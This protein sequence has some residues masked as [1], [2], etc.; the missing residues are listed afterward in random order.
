MILKGSQRGGARQLSGHLMNRRDNEHVSLIEVRGFVGQSLDEALAEAHAI[1]KGTKCSQ[2]LFSLSMN[3]PADQPVGEE[4]LLRAADAAEERLGLEGQPRAV[5]VHE[6]EGRRHAHVVWSRIDPETMHAINLPFFKQRL[7]ELSRELYL[8]QDWPLP[9]GM[10]QNGGK[11]PL[12]FTLAEWQQAKRLGLDPRE[13]KQVFRDAWSRSDSRPAFERA[14][15]E[16]GYFLAKGDRR[17]FVAVDVHGD[18]FAISK[19]AGVRAREVEQR[20]GNPEALRDVDAVRQDI[21][22]R[23]NDRLKGFIGEVKA[24]HGEA[25]A[26][27]DAERQTMTRAHAADRTRLEQ[28]QQ[29]RQREEQQARQA[30]FNRGLRGLWDKLTGREKSI[31]Q[32]NETEALLAM[33]RDR[34]QRDQLAAAQI[35]QR[36]RL[37]EQIEA[38]RRQQAEERKLLAREVARRMRQQTRTPNTEPARNRTRTRT[39]ASDPDLKP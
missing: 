14:L 25:R 10:R 36:R 20:F 11:S 8:E 15:E 29:E 35:E 1:A 39:R 32:H 27:L 21:R 18:V 38:L 12:N 2:F 4:A 31:R 22:Q 19:W 16:R 13:L 24:R 28:L 3:P 7:T 26:P 30:K 33:R 5:V 17:G 23:L 9:E 37:Q 6:K 34:A